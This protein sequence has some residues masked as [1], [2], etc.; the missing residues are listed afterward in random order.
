MELYSASG[1]DA[2]YH[3]IMYCY[4]N[5]RVRSLRIETSRGYRLGFFRLTY[6]ARFADR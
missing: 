4:Y 5:S 6:V 2:G 3:E 1:T